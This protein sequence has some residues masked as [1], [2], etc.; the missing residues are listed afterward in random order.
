MKT[1]LVAIM[2]LLFATSPCM[3]DIFDAK[4]TEL[5]VGRS[6]PDGTRDWLE[7]TNLGNTPIDT[8]DI[9]Y[10]D[11][12][13]DI[14][15]ALIL[16]SFIL[17]PGETAIFLID[18]DADDPQYGNAGKEFL[19]VW[20]MFPAG[21]NLSG[22]QADGGL[23]SSNRD[24]ANLMDLSGNIIDTFA[25]EPA[26]DLGDFRTMERI[27]EG[28][29]DH[30][31]SIL[32]ENGAYISLCFNDPDTGEKEVDGNGDPVLLVGSPGVFN[33]FMDT[34]LGDINCDGE[35]NLL[36]VGPFV[37]LLNSGGFSPKADINGDGLLNLLDVGP[38][39]DLLSG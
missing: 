29:T 5:W 12:S 35:I 39:V 38:F 1:S 31:P 13:A 11:V 28:T 16:P 34:L 37:D 22:G 8:G 14:N 6:G 25:Y 26:V 27:G 2:T 18:I 23:S 15:V 7:V 20:D 4:I 33:G 9:A 19:A 3:A 10:D 30:R 32:G 17:D 21:G 24:A 36:D